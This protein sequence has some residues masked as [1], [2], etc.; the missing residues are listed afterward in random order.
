[1]NELPLATPTVA[2]P[3]LVPGGGEMD[4]A[5][6]ELALLGAGELGRPQ[7][8][9]V[10]GEVLPSLEVAHA[11]AHRPPEEVLLYARLSHEKPAGRAGGASGLRGN[12]GPGS[13]AL[14]SPGATSLGASA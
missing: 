8:R 7:E 10:G 6:G 2:E 5:A 13:G 14:Y 11:H 1:M 9:P 12:P 3:P 4:E